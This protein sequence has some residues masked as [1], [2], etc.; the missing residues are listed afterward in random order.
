MIMCSVMH[1]P[2]STG[3]YSIGE[4]L[5]PIFFL[6]I[7]AA[8]TEWNINYFTSFVLLNFHLLIG[9][10]ASNKI[11]LTPDWRT[12]IWTLILVLIRFLYC[13]ISHVLDNEICALRPVT[14]DVSWKHAPGLLMSRCVIS[15]TSD[16][17]QGDVRVFNWYNQHITHLEVVTY[18]IS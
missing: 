6:S 14:F 4:A 17:V 16:Q 11:E 7:H 8:S 12:V 13:E 5:G 10:I 3:N 9:Q 2:K 1:R 15:D 18:D